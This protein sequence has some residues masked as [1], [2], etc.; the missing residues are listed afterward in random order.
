MEKL[1]GQW[2]RPDGGYI[3]EVRSVEP[4]GR[5]TAA[6][7]NPRPINVAKAEVSQIGAT[8]RIV[9]VLSDVNYPGSTYT[10]SYDAAG[11]VLR[12]T[13][14]Q[15]AIGQTFDVYFVRRQR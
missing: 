2:Q 8:V 14:F 15:A 10:L 12:G 3:L 13:Y 4:D 5:I 9:I 1:I 7:F 6:Y 11:D